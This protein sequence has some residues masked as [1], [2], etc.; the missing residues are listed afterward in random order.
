VHVDEPDTGVDHVHVGG[1][2][3]TVWVVM[4]HDIDGCYLYGVFSKK[5]FAEAYIAA[6]S[7]FERERI[8]MDEIIV[9]RGHI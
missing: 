8:A 7:S 4:A 9:D 3:L 6:C 1:S 2:G 5:S